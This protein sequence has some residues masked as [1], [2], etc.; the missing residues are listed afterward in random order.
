MIGIESPKMAVLSSVEIINPKL[1]E[2]V[3]ADKLRKM[4]DNGELKGCIV[5][6]LSL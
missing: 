6:F 1:K 3:K 2:T 4:N 5:M